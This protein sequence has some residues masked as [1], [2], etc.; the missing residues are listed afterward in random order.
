M[1]KEFTIEFTPNLYIRGRIIDYKY[2]IFTNIGDENEYRREVFDYECIAKGF[3]HNVIKGNINKILDATGYD[4]SHLPVN[5]YHSIEDCPFCAAAF[6]KICLKHSAWTSWFTSSRNGSK[7]FP[8]IMN[9]GFSTDDYDIYIK[10]T[11]AITLSVYRR[12][13]GILSFYSKGRWFSF[14]V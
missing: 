1:T 13:E 8:D 3:I 2:F 5:N 6:S 10:P 9:I 12:K 14:F 7:Y 11:R 4:P